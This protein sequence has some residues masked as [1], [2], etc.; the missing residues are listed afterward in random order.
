M[1]KAIYISNDN[2]DLLDTYDRLGLK[3]TLLFKMFALAIPRQEA[4][5]RSNWWRIDIEEY[6]ESL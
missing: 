1:I 4:T 5:Q 6:E 3:E 2:N